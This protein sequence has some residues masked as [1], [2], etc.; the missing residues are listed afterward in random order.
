MKKDFN[1]KLEKFS[2]AIE[3]I[4]VEKLFLDA[5]KETAEL[6]LDLNK[7]QML[8]LGVDSQNKPLGQYTEGTKARKRKK[9]QPTDHIT[10][11][12]TSPR[13]WTPMGTK[14]D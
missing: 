14:Q 12:D 3:K 6:A 7:V 11:R 5:I 1:R 8:E 9:G 4:N 13:I 2:K 10:L